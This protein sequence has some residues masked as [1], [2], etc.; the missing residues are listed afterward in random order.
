MRKCS[1]AAEASIEVVAE[2]LETGGAETGDVCAEFRDF[3]LCHE[4]NANTAK[5]KPKATKF[6]KC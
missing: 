5:M 4:I 1:I 3:D 2:I 6:P